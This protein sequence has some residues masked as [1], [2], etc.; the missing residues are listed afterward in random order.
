[1]MHKSGLDRYTLAGLTAIAMWSFSVS[2]VRSIS[3]QVGSFTTIAAVFLTGG[4]LLL[5]REFLSGQRTLYKMGVS[6]PRHF[7]GCGLLM[8]IYSISL[9]LGLGMAQDRIQTL[10]IGLVNFLWPTFTILFSLV[11][12]HTK[13]RWTLAPSTILALMGI[14]M[15]VTQGRRFSPDS[16]I[17]NILGNPLAYGLGLTAALSWGLYSNLTQVWSETEDENS[18]SFFMIFIGVILT[19]IS[20]FK[21]EPRVFGT[22]VVIEIIILG[23]STATSYSFWDLSMRKG[24]ANLVASCA[25]FTPLLSAAVGCLYLQVVPGHRLWLGCLMIITGSYLSWRSVRDD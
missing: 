6:T 17:L 18:V 5:S 16:F 11:F 12:S 14:L 15:V 10:E 3:E 7:I 23:V 13:A 19:L 4:V 1:M 21:G 2:L 9:Y 22:R 24:R 8:T 25:Y 20:L